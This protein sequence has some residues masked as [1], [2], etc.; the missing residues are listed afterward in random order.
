[1]FLLTSLQFFVYCTQDTR[2]EDADVVIDGCIFD[3]NKADVDGGGAYFAGGYGSQMTV[4]INNSCFTSNT[5]E[6]YGGGIVFGDLKSLSIQ[7]TD[8]TGN[9][10]QVEGGGIHSVVSR[11][12]W[13]LGVMFSSI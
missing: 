12:T 13:T 10:A 8:F 5:A 11:C 6:R 7:N 1:M 4:T 2:G 9:T 3:N